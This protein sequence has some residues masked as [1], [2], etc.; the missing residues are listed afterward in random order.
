MERRD[1]DLVPAFEALRGEH[2]HDLWALVVHELA[3]AA[4]PALR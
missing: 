1:E 3:C 4:G 2:D